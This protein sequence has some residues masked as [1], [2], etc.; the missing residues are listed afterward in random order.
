MVHKRY[1][2][3][4][5][6]DENL[7]EIIQICVGTLEKQ[8]KNI[9]KTKIIVKLYQDDNNNY[10]VLEPYTELNHSQSFALMQ[11]EEW[12]EQIGPIET[13]AQQTARELKIISGTG[14]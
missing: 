11:T 8:R 6:D 7:N 10:E 5:L 12:Q 3:V 9:L 13:R 4:N 1:F 14:Y 2:A